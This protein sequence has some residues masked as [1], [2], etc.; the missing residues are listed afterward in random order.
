MVER[1]E[2]QIGWI[3]RMA[4]HTIRLCKGRVGS[5]MGGRTDL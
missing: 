1:C 4:L 2:S 3:Q 5:E